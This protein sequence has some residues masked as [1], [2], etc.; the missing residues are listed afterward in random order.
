MRTMIMKIMHKRSRER[1]KIIRYSLKNSLTSL[2]FNL[3]IASISLGNVLEFTLQLHVALSKI[4]CS[5]FKALEQTHS[6]FEESQ[7]LST[8]HSRHFLSSS[9]SRHSHSQVSFLHFCL[10]EQSFSCILQPHSH[11]SSSST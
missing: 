7:T 1:I 10:S 6:H 8:T 3:L 5:Q 11:S 9:L 4:P 2:D